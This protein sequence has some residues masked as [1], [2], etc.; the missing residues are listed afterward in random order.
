[1]GE[2]EKTRK[3]VKPELSIEALAEWLAA[4]NIVI[5][6]NI[7]THR[8]EVAGLDAAF[9]RETLD[10]NLPVILSDALKRKYRCTPSTV[11][12]LLGVIAGL[13]RY[14]PVLKLLESSPAWDG[15]DRFEALFSALHIDQAD[16]LSRTL[17]KKS[18]Y[19]A[20][21][22]LLNESN[23][24]FGADGLLCLLGRQGIGKTFFVSWLGIMPEFVKL[25]AWVDFRDKDSVIRATSSWITELGE[26]ETTLRTDT[27]RLKAF[28]TA[29]AD[30]YRLPY[31]R[32][33]S[34]LLRRT[35]FI[36]TANSERLLVDPT[37]SRRFWTVALDSIDL[38]A[39]QKIDVVQLWKQVE[40]TVK[41]KG[42]HCFRLSKEDQAALAER[43]G[44]HE[45]PLRAQEECEDILAA[46]ER[47]PDNWRWEYVTVSVF[48]EDHASLRAY[49]VE[50][51]GKALDRLGIHQEKK[52]VDGK[53]GRFR[54]LPR[55]KY[56]NM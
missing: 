28:I 4:N 40:A 47:D 32:A 42:L 50:A 22:L 19:Q 7:L 44:A 33:D 24:P 1:M 16:G 41:E 10:S 51:I 54:F 9:D 2:N 14:N 49:S 25:G 13:M 34:N 8:N 11:A 26:L 53:Q 27:E 20:F 12:D 36:A 21:A 17:I 56:S 29:S 37:G 3:A 35:S 55:R 31:A 45:R 52:R 18:L 6:R 30:S 5:R 15:V 39:L 38:D 48:K 46:A 43:N 23:T